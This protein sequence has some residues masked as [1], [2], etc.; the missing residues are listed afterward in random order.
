MIKEKTAI[1]YRLQ[2]M[3]DMVLTGIA[4]S[5]AYFFRKFF[6][7]ENLGPLSQDPN[8]LFILLLSLVLFSVGYKLT[9]IYEPFKRRTIGQI[10]EKFFLGSIV[11]IAGVTLLLYLLKV[12]TV[13]RVM[14]GLFL[15]FNTIILAAAKLAT[16]YS[17]KHLMKKGLNYRNILIVG[18]HCRAMDLKK[19]I[20]ESPG[21]G[22]RITGFISVS[23]TPDTQDELQSNGMQVTAGINEFERILLANPID[24]VIF[25]LPPEEI[26]ELKEKIRFTE[27]L[28]VNVRVMPE[29]HLQ[30]LMYQPETA[31]VH[32]DQ[33]FGFF[34][35]TLSSLPQAHGALL[36]KTILD[37]ASA[38]AGAVLLSPIFIAIAIAVKLDS[39]G[40]ILFTQE[41]CGLN[42]RRFVLY[43][44][45]TMAEDA[46]SRKECLEAC[47]E[48]DGPTFKVSNDPRIT[49][50]G[51][52][53]RKTSLDELP[54]LFNILK[55][56]M[57]L[58]GPRP[59]IPGEVEQYR[60]WQRRRLSMKPGLTCIWQVKGRH[61]VTFED[62][63]RMDMEYIDNWSLL[64][65]LKLILQTIP[66]ILRGSGC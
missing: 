16:L 55:G 27:R 45:R 10:L 8:Y 1:V 66:S 64:L 57:S 65:D 19:A 24:E 56:E 3:L 53:L 37:Y 26:K 5:L 52:F 23:G 4:F 34:T 35:I 38:L 54:Q 22:Y 59:P 6:L 58:V 9:G 7:N 21:S 50:I 60:S 2:V 44:F 33:F 36:V 13:S 30:D 41:R 62:W 25:A 14:I 40:P 51:G 47:N 48:S 28:G 17:L 42:G 46:E 39:R 31:D 12:Q 63:M 61:E 49:S 29:W 43:K 15:A 11:G 18:S 32:L 20:Q